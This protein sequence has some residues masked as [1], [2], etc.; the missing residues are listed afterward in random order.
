MYERNV[1]G[2]D[3]SIR[4]VLGVIFAALGL[5]FVGSAIAKG[6]LFAL[7]AIAFITALTGFCPLNK[8]I[9]LNTCKRPVWVRKSTV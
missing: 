5:F 6:I 2:A 3:R 4:I 9:G 8:L 7:A 1:C